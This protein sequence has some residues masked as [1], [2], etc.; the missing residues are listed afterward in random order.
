MTIICQIFDK[1]VSKRDFLRIIKVKIMWEDHKNLKKNPCRFD[2]YS[3][4]SKS[5]KGTLEYN[6]AKGKKLYYILEYL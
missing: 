3:V 6:F 1:I 2:V 4:T 5:N